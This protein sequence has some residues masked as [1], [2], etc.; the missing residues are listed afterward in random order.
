MDATSEELYKIKDIGEILSVN[1]V[2]YFKDENN[3]NEINELKKLGINM[4]SDTD[5]MIEDNNFKDKRFVITG[6]F[7]GITRDE[8][9]D[10]IEKRGGFTSDSVSKKTSVVL[11]GKDP[12]SKKDK[13]NELNIPIWNQD[14]LFNIMRIVEK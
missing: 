5:E 9:K 6:S 11:V 7:D 8:I 10:Y 2:E 4:N 14:K 13:A 12:G 3:I 1:V